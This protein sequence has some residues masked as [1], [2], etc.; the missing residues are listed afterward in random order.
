[1]TR[2]V[3]ME[4]IYDVVKKEGTFSFSYSQISTLVDSLEALGI[5]SFEKES[6]PALVNATDEA[7]CLV[8]RYSGTTQQFIYRLESNGYKIVKANVPAS[9]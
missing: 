2:T 9:I 6:D 4:A 5:L 7:L 1:M 8:R 3:A